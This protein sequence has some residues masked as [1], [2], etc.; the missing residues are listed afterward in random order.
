MI[1]PSGMVPESLRQL[2]TRGNEI[3]DRVIEML[4]A[5]AFAEWTR[6]A[7]DE[8]HTTAAAYAA[9]IQ[10]P[11]FVSSGRAEIVLTGVLPNLVE[12]GQAP[13]DMRA[14]LCWNPNA[15]NRKEI[16]DKLPDGKQ[17]TVIGY[18]NII[19]LRHG[20][21]GVTGNNFPAM[22]APYKSETLGK[23][24]YSH[25]KDL[26][27]TKRLEE[28][29]FTLHGDRLPETLPGES[30]PMPKLKS[31]HT[32]SIY[33]GM[34]KSVSAYDKAVQA[35]YMTWRVISTEGGDPSSWQSP[36]IV[37]RQFHRR[38]GEFLGTIAQA[39]VQQVVAT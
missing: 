17:G 29:G 19:P 15:K 23:L 2:G 27:P 35:Q 5:A 8:L 38:V 10:D 1:D 37:P 33:T 39:V 4:A 28:A 21:P 9:A 6:L 14:T 20:T 22:G 13:Y 7:Q 12:Q 32:T 31:S 36:G 16:H 26:L 34:V 24:V 11:V 3:R 25:A 18:Y 30:R